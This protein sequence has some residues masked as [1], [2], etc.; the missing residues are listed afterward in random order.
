M[1]L[2][3]ETRFRIVTLTHESVMY[4]LLFKGSELVGGGFVS[5]S[6]HGPLLCD[7]TNRQ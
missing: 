4:C 7:G 5:D 1:Q 6:H 2:D 3:S